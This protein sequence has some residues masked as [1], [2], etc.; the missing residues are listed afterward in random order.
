[1]AIQE[2]AVTIQKIYIKEFGAE[3]WEKLTPRLKKL[4]LNTD[5]LVKTQKPVSRQWLEKA[6]S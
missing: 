4:F 6:L 1:M 5:A 3:A 2:S